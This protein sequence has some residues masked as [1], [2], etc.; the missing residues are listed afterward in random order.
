MKL[1]QLLEST[2]IERNAAKY[3]WA[4]QQLD[5]NADFENVV[6]ILTQS[7]SSNIDGP[8]MIGLVAAESSFRPDVVHHNGGSN[9]YGLFQLNNLWHDQSKGNIVKHI[10]NGV[11]HFKWCLKTEKGNIGRA[12]SRYNTGG[13]DN[14]AGTQYDGYVMRKKN[15]ITNK[16][17]Q[18]SAKKS[19]R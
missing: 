6:R 17:K 9:D 11:N 12:L 2:S 7:Q 18:Y 19:V 3:F 4:L 10:E 5:Y 8:L 1:E 14:A 13:G 15:A 16:A